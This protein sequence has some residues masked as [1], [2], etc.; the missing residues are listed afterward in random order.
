MIELA[1]RGIR[2]EFG[3]I[4]TSVAA[5]PLARDRYRLLLPLVIVS[6]LCAHPSGSAFAAEADDC[7]PLPTEKTELACSAII[8]DT[9]RSEPD[10]TRAHVNRAR[11][12]SNGAKFDLALADAESAL[13]LDAR[14][15]PA[16]LLRGY[17]KSL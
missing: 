1:N 12:Y 5:R 10:R 15:V 3:G 7:G 11:G 8:N 14:P 16:L 2:R 17:A 13:R 9:A 4:T 6:C